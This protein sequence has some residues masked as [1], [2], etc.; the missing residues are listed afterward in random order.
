MKSEENTT[1]KRTP[2]P[3][4]REREFEI[5]GLRRSADIMDEHGCPATAI[6]L[7]N[8]AWVLENSCEWLEYIHAMREDGQV[9]DVKVKP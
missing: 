7:R 9:D 1:M 2:E 8:Q 3:P 6:L 4:D 5:A